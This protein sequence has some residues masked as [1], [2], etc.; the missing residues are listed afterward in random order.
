M[1]YPASNLYAGAQMFYPPAAYAVPTAQDAAATRAAVM[2][3]VRRQ[4]EYYFSVEN[5]C[6]DIFLRSKVGIMD[7]HH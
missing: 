3:S 4:I 2:E 1:Y 6:K 5:L 7:G